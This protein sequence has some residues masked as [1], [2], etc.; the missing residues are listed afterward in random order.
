MG[1]RPLDGAAVSYLVWDPRHP[2]NA[3]VSLPRTVTLHAICAESA[4]QGM[5]PAVAA[6]RPHA[7][8]VGISRS[9]LAEHWRWALQL[10][11]TVISALLQD[12]RCMCGTGPQP[13]QILPAPW[14]WNH[15]ALCLRM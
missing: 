1:A 5:D 9:D 10:A 13:L 7:V 11:S 15:T 2:A 6:S 12:C 3:G 14:S 8:R 4:T